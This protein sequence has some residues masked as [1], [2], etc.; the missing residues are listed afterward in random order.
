MRYQISPDGEHIFYT[1]DPY[2]E[3]DIWDDK[4]EECE[5][6]TRTLVSLGGGNSTTLEISP[7][8]NP[9]WS[10]DSSKILFFGPYDMANNTQELFVIRADGSGLANLTPPINDTFQVSWSFDSTSVAL[11]ESAIEGGYVLTV[12]DASGLNRQELAPVP[13]DT[14]TGFAFEGFSWP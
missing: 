10:P 12:V 9:K 6:T 11:V 14:A 13:W 2:Y 1:L 8:S 4:Q 5:S 7:D 3:G